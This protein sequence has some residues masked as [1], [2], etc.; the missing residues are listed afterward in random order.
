MR[1]AAICPTCATYYN[2]V[3]IIYDGQALPNTSIAPM[4]NLQDALSL[5]DT[6]IGSINALLGNGYNGDIDTGSQILT[7]A[8]GLLVS[9]A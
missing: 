7:F 9:V 5:I 1:T 2:A 4:T 3:C 8:N 6:S